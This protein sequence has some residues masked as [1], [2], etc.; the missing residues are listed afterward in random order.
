MFKIVSTL[1]VF[2]AFAFAGASAPTLA[3]H[4]TPGGTLSVDNPRA[5]VVQVFVDDRFEA[6]VA[7]RSTRRITLR[8]GRHEVKLRLVSGKAL[9]ESR[10]Q[11]RRGKTATLRVPVL[12]TRTVRLTN[13]ANKDIAIYVDGELEARVRA[14][15][16]ERM[17]L[18]IG[19]HYILVVDSQGRVLEDR[20]LR[21]AMYGSTSLVIQD[22][23]A[24]R[25]REHERVSTRQ[26][27]SRDEVQGS[28]HAHAHGV[29]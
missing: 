21:V 17:E 13:R 16:N 6:V 12:E 19:T 27:A 23:G 10:L 2:V 9:S 14:G 15:R 11:V 28:V 5:E 22:P 7:P 8:E 26:R 24:Q 18:P 3:A 1:L 25:A 29:H 4:A 20:S